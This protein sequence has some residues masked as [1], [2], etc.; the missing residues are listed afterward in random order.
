ML[1]KSNFL[2]S[3]KK[4]NKKLVNFL[5]LCNN[6]FCGRCFDE[7]ATKHSNGNIYKF[8]YENPID[9]NF[10]EQFT[11]NFIYCCD[12]YDNLKDKE[13]FFNENVYEDST[14]LGN[15]LFLSKQHESK[16]S[17][18]LL[19]IIKHK[20]ELWAKHSP[21]R[22]FLPSAYYPNYNNEN[23]KHIAI[24]VSDLRTMRCFAHGFNLNFQGLIPLLELKNKV[25]FT[26]N[27]IPNGWGKDH[28][29]FSLNE[30]NLIDKNEWIYCIQDVTKPSETWFPINKLSQYEPVFD[31]NFIKGFIQLTDKIEGCIICFK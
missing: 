7:K 30:N 31:I 1:F 21:E 19:K 15:I 26:I 17:K 20:N 5:N 8:I 16:L 6:A 23:N 12:F 10:W 13:F 11:A 18:I 29:Y 27:N 4:F 24:E 22:C 9:E 28:H 14:K 3:I 25:N 2:L